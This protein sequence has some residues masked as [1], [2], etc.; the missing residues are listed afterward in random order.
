MSDY[1][2]AQRC[3]GRTEHWVKDIF[4]RSNRC[5]RDPAE[6]NQ[7]ELPALHSAIHDGK[8]A[9]SG[10]ETMDILVLGAGIV[11][12]STAVHLQ[13]R[14][15]NVILVDKDEPA[16]AASYGNAGM[17]H[18]EAAI[19]TSFPRDL[20]SIIRFGFNNTAALHYHLRALPELASFLAKYWWYSEPTRLLKIAESYAALTKQSRAEHVALANA[21]AVSSLLRSD[22]CFSIY[23]SRQALEQGRAEAERARQHFDVNYALFST[24]EFS[25]KEPHLSGIAGAVHWA[26]SLTAAD[27]HDVAAGYFR[28]FKKLGGSFVHGRAENII[29]E[30]DG[31]SFSAGSKNISAQTVIVAL[32]A[33]SDQF[34]RS[35]GYKFPLKAKR[36]YHLHYKTQGNIPLNHTLIDR[37]NGFSLA[38]MKRGVRLTTGIEFARIDAPK[39]PIQ[40]AR[41]EQSVRK[42]FPLGNAI[43]TE[44]WMGE[45]P[46]MP[47]MLPV[48]GK[49]PDRDNLWFAFGHGHQGFTMG[50]VTGRLLA[51]MITGD[52]PIIDPYPYRSERFLT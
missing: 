37:V 25:E 42:I 5:C 39:T 6:K 40:M 41:A 38:P 27:P 11:G 13:Q 16:M 9:L 31:W 43:E 4:T 22:G 17:I 19:P 47:D 34:T 45:R 32:G 12:I 49:A 8:S 50:P 23:R 51:E 30:Q 21:A 33:W 52:E 48:I 35:L 20:G 15:I 2:R 10:E 28:Y 3:K 18:G 7:P 24:D 29:A 36:G 26:D 46:C 1:S 14:G 44:P